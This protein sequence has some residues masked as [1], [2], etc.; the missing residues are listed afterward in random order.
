MQPVQNLNWI[1]PEGLALSEL[2]KV[3]TDTFAVKFGPVKKMK[4]C[5]YDTFDWRLYR[6]EYLL[7]RE[8]NLWILEDFQGRQLASLNSRRKSFRFAWDFPHSVLRGILKK[9]LDVRALMEIGTENLEIVSLC[10]L[11]GD[12]KIVALVD[13]QQSFSGAGETPRVS[14]HI[15]EI[16]GYT[17]WFKQVAAVL[18][19][20]AATTLSGPAAVLSVV[21]Q[22]TGRQP[23]DYSSGYDVPLNPEMTSLEAV[24][25]IYSF[26]LNCMQRNVNGVLAD[27]DSEFLHDLRVAVRRTRSALSLIRDV[28]ATEISMRFKDEFSYIGQVTGPVRD[29]DVYLLSEEAYKDRLPQRL[30]EGL[31]YFFKDLASRR[32]REQDKLVRA[33]RGQRF[34][35]ILSDWRQILDGETLVAGEKGSTPVGILASQIVHKRFR[36]VLKDGKKIHGNTPDSELHRLRIQCK[37]L[38]YSLE[39]FSPLYDGQQMKLLLRQ[40]KMLQNNLG[41]F[42]DLSVQQDMLAEYLVSTRS[43]SKKSLE[44]AASIGGLMTDLARQHHEVRTHFEATFAHFSRPK[45]MRLYHE[46]FG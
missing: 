2:Q 11:N 22:E 34:R 41:D 24:R 38:R 23:L 9:K 37:K 10:I 13:L 8:G 30:Q 29:L 1:V 6:E 14:V 18:D 4:R 25:Q 46:I 28:L 42:N 20:V 7:F 27:I 12:K 43:G 33:L 5:W 15:Q 35:Q 17:K 39:F 21:L 19:N 45:N 3:F 32:K 40:L 44:L 36:R 31:D 26:L 16:R